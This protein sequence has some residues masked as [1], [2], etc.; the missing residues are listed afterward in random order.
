MAITTKERVLTA[1]LS[2]PG[3][4]LSGDQ[5]A[6]QAGISRESVWKAVNALRQRGHQIISRKNRGYQYV[7]GAQLD[8]TAIRYYLQTK[9]TGE[10]NVVSTTASTQ[11]LAK[12]FLTSGVIGPA[13]F[14]ADQQTAGYG[15]FG[16]EFYSPATTGLYLSLVLPNP[17]NDLTHAGLLTTGVVVAV[18][19]VLERYFP[20]KDFGIKWVNDI[21]LDQ[22]KVGGIITEANLELESTSAA[23]FIVGIGL[24]LTTTDFPTDLQPIA[25][26][27]APRQTVDRNQLVAD[28]IEQVLTTYQTYQ[29][30][31]FLPRYRAKSIVIGRQV[32]LKIGRQTVTGKAIGIDQQGGLIVQDAA[33]QSTSYQS[34]EVVKVVALS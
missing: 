18:L 12:Q 23:A 1:L 25:Q 26:G 27:I 29:R 9:F 31:A 7:P 4:W 13:A 10:L 28:L 22:R 19:T 8:E 32:T 15:R 11:R 5:L 3:A 2:R 20:E 30:G 6:R 34:G 33:S 17:A 14:I 24:N 16:R 21:V